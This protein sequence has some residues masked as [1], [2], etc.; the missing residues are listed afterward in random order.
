M[1]KALE[2][3][4]SIKLTYRRAEATHRD[5]L[6]R[7]GKL[8]HEFVLAY[9]REGDG[10]R[11]RARLACAITRD[12]AIK[13]AAEEVGIPAKR[14]RILIAA[15]MTAE[16][17]APEGGTGELGHNAIYSFSRFV[18][19]RPGVRKEDREEVSGSET[20][21]IKPDF[22]D[23]AAL[24]FAR[25]VKEN[26]SQDRA[27]LET[28]NLFRNTLP[29]A[30]HW[31]GEEDREEERPTLDLAAIAPHASTGD[32]AESLFEIVRKAEDPLA[33]AERLLSMVRQEVKGR[34]R[35]HSFAS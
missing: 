5:E 28:M 2:I 14:V 18:R 32:L 13:I 33:V 29:S 22:Q 31:K 15:A 21:E 35:K 26:W 30:S 6:L 1:S 34:A 8:L 23:R 4:A 9:L 25:A 7:V 16:L 12:T 11:E 10:K 20:W 24:T 3:L 19:R 17:L 27:R